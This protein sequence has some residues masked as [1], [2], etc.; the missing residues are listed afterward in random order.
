MTVQDKES[1]QAQ[2]DVLLASGKAGGIVAI[3]HRTVE[4]DS[5]DSL[6]SYKEAYVPY[7][8]VP[9][10]VV[11]TD[12]GTKYL[13]L[14]E[15]SE[16]AATQLCGETTTDIPDSP[17]WTEVSTSGQVLLLHEYTLTEDQLISEIEIY[18]PEA[19]QNLPNR[20]YVIVTG[21]NPGDVPVST[22]LPTIA[23]GSPNWRVIQFGNVTYRTGTKIELYQ[24]VLNGG[25][26]NS[27][28]MDLNYIGQSLEIPAANG[29]WSRNGERNQL[30][31]YNLD[32][33]GVDRSADL[34]A[35][36]AG[37]SIKLTN[38]QGGIVGEEN[39]SVLNST[40]E[41]GY[42]NIEVQAAVISGSFNLGDDTNL[43]AIYPITPSA[44]YPTILGYYVNQPSFAAVQA[45]R[46]VDNVAT[47]TDDAFGMR[48]RSTPACFSDDW[49]EVGG[50]TAALSAGAQRY[51]QG[52]YYLDAEQEPGVAYT[53]EPIQFPKFNV[54]RNPSQILVA[55]DATGQFGFTGTGQAFG[56]LYLTW[57]RNG[58][59][60]VQFAYVWLEL[61]VDG[62]LSWFSFGSPVPVSLRNN[63]ITP[64]DLSFII[65]N[66]EPTD[67]YRFTIQVSDASENI[68]LYSEL[69]SDIGPSGLDEP[70]LAPPQEPEGVRGAIMNIQF[71]PSEV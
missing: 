13:S 15:T 28:A 16:R 62:G 43:D 12:G 51:V 58:G 38:V 8:T 40:A 61:S 31:I 32:N 47:P 59:G 68:R 35:L 18:V 48:I 9:A 10:R 24:A 6:W 57:A 25:A 52:V 70:L 69:A 19:S 41:A 60:A 39:Y 45:Y 49:T 30:N 20:F 66:I 2:K 65:A 50:G 53:R 21:P 11:V 67:L 71:Y 46:V 23:T 56:H 29:Q 22:V 63:D 17:V 36:V 14:R 4:A 27:F 37:S 7:E 64:V 3:D 34:A 1:L 26:L 33:A 42:F 5:I 44:T 55:S 54:F